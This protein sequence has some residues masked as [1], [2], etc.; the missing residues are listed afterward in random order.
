MF[1]IFY[2]YAAIGTTLFREIN[3]VLWGDIAISLL[4]LFRVMAFEDWTDVMYE[5]MTIYPL[6][7]IYYL[8]FIV[9]TAIAFLNVIIGVVVNSLE[10]EDLQQ[11]RE[12]GEPTLEVLQSELNEIKTLLKDQNRALPKT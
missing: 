6:S 9:F 8:T 4:T 3:H 2:I 5:T 11:S 12:K 7:W 10:E 1:I